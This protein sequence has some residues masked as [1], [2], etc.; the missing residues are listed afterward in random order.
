M[1][2]RIVKTYGWETDMT[3]GEAIDFAEYYYHMGVETKA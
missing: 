1:R 3:V 2:W